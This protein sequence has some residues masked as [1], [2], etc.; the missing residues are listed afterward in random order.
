ME[1]LAKHR[2]QAIGAEGRRAA[3]AELLL[4]G[5]GYNRS[6]IAAR[7]SVAVTTIIRDETL[8]RKEWRLARLEDADALVAQD[9]AELAMVKR[10][11]WD[12]YR[13]SLEPK[14]SKSIQVTTPIVERT[15]EKTGET[16]K[17]VLKAGTQTEGATET[18]PIPNLKALELVTKC[19]ERKQKLLGYGEDA[20][21][22]RD[23]QRLFAF[24]LKIGDKIL[25]AQ[26]SDIEAEHIEA[27]DAEYYEVDSNGKKM[28]MSGGDDEG[29]GVQ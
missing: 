17:T 27:E 14:T 24:T 28:L 2:A 19:L 11:A 20:E 9:L 12:A 25:A 10:C 16:A 13:D 18:T 3:I 22:K 21:K 29:G 23:K 1:M 15:D 6:Q 4:T 8:I 26:S 5:E 7:F